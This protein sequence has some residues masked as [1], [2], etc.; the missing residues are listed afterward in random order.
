MIRIL[1]ADDH[2]IVRSALRTLIHSERDWEICCEV[3]RGDEIVDAVQTTKPDIAIL[4]I[5]MPG[6]NGVAAARL[7]KSCAPSVGIMFLTEQTDAET[8]SGAL[9]AGAR[10]YVLKTDPVHEIVDAIVSLSRQRTH[11]TTV[12]NELLLRSG[13]GESVASPHLLFTSREIQ[14]LTLVAE[15]SCNKEIARKLDISVKTV[16]SHR[17]KVMS[18]ANVNRSGALVRY[19]AQNR[20]FA[21]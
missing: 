10:G 4:D 19:A 7:V 16:E 18:K 20:L 5:G 2:P 12:V 11:F 6:L 3:D 17:A 1:I 13:R 14:V 9:G 15:G 21:V 8:I